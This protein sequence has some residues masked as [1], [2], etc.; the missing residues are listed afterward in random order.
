[1]EIPNSKSNT[2]KEKTEDFGNGVLFISDTSIP[3]LTAYLPD[4]GKA[5]GTAVV[6]CPGGGYGGV[7]ILHEGNQV[8]EAFRKMGVA[9]FVLKNR[10]PSE[11]T[12]Q[13]K[14]IGPLQ[15][16]QRALQMVRQKAKEWNVNIDK[17]GVL[18]FSAGGHL[19]AT[20]ASHF[21]NS[22]IENKP[23]I[24]LRPDFS[25]L[26]YPVISFT[27]SLTH[28][29][30]RENLI[31]KNPSKEQIVFFS[32]ELQVSKK[33]PAAFL[34]HAGDDDAVQ[35]ENVISFYRALHQHGIEAQLLIYPKGGHGFGL[36]NPS[37]TDKWMDAC[38]RWMQGNGWLG[39][40]KNSDD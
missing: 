10:T 32:N 2:V 26:V 24:N 33:S 39:K 4:A 14:S 23:G 22:F 35:V 12:M 9:A 21:G 19:A 6:I 34:V 29:G 18:G 1:G 38:E 20:A 28:I 7:A 30:S 40:S 17:V 8:A 25:I 11:R 37:T 15:D 3:T 31:G 5:N 13:D 36:N 16:V 27:D